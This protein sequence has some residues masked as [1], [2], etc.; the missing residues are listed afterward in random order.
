MTAAEKV[1]KWMRHYYAVHRT[2]NYSE[3]TAQLERAIDEEKQKKS[4]KSRCCGR[5][6]GVNDLCVSDM[7]CEEHNEQGCEIC[8]GAR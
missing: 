5:C 7:I 4:P 3:I 6:D 8:Y 2:P 1:L